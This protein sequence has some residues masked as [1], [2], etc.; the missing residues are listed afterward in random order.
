MERVQLWC[1]HDTHDFPNPHWIL[2]DFPRAKPNQKN[3]ICMENLQNVFNWVF[4]R[5]VRNCRSS[6]CHW[7]L[8]LQPWPQTIQNMCLWAVTDMCL[9]D[10]HYIIGGVNMDVDSGALQLR[11]KL[12]LND[13]PFCIFHVLLIWRI[14]LHAIFF[15]IKFLLLIVHKTKSKHWQHRQFHQGK[16]FS[17]SILTMCFFTFWIS[18]ICFFQ[19]SKQTWEEQRNVKQ[20]NCC[21]DNPAKGK[22]KANCVSWRVTTNVRMH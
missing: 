18:G 9:A 20:I 19:G 13:A 4:C 3:D 5:G 22:F 17:I 2:Q 10:G 21:L 1:Q 6:L 12:K 15:Y 11:K 14:H 8:T 7:I 16:Q